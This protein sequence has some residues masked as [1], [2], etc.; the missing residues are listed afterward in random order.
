MQVGWAVIGRGPDRLSVRVATLGWSRSSYV[1]FCD[2]EKVETLVLA[3]E[4]AFAAFGG[5]PRE[6]LYDNVKTVVL[7]RNTYGRGHHRFHSGFLDYGGHAG[8]VAASV[9]SLPRQDER[10]GRTLHPLFEGEPF[11]AV[12]QGLKQADLRP[13]K[14]AANA[15]VARW[16]REIANARVHGTTGEV[17]A[18]RQRASPPSAS[19]IYSRLLPR[20]YSGRSIRQL[21]TPAQDR[22][23]QYEE[24]VMGSAA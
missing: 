5:I 16:L 21:Q 20:P 24:L 7:E 13:D 2:D 19:S 17:P 1:E 18:E 12:C 8:F 14:D 4:H 22:M 23:R 9:S 11:G 10:Q 6:V 15:A 3:H